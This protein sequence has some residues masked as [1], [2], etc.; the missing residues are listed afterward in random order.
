MVIDR[1]ISDGKPNARASSCVNGDNV[2]YVCVS[3]RWIEINASH[4]YYN[5]LY[6]VLK[7]TMH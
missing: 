7:K 6:N 5:I 2:V 3:D 4:Q 1:K